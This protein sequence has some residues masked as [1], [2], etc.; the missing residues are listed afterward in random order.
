MKRGLR[1]VLEDKDD[2]ELLK[3]ELYAFQRR[4]L[5]ICQRDHQEWR[6]RQM[7]ETLGRRLEANIRS[8]GNTLKC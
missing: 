5:D 4:D 3:A 7:D 1:E 6:I 2:I 8:E